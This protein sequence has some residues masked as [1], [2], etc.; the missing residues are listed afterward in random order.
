M[1]VMLLMGILLFGIV[2]FFGFQW[3]TATP[4]RGAR[5]AAHV[6][7]PMEPMADF[8][9][10]PQ[11]PNPIPAIPGQT[12]EEQQ[13]REPLQQRGSPSTQQPNGGGGGGGGLGPAEFEDNLRHPEQQFQMMPAQP[14]GSHL[15]IA[16]IPSSGGSHV[17]GA[18]AQNEG[19]I[20]GGVFAFD[21]IESS[22]MT[23]F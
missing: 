20:V 7:V 14:G 10:E 4:K 23:P 17:P 6:P 11:P 21:G 1:D 3:W 9:P 13:Q 2:A 19:P 15:H 8:K 12:M 16:E 22:G 18:A 5:L